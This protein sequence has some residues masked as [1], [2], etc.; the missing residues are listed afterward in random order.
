MIF[1]IDLYVLIHVQRVCIYNLQSYSGALA[2]NELS[3]KIK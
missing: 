2:D 1:Y 3:N